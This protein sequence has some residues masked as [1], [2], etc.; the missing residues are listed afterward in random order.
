MASF[1]IFS[2]YDGANFDNGLQDGFRLS[3]TDSH[4]L[5]SSKKILLVPIDME[6][7]Q[8]Y[9]SDGKLYS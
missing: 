7:S 6:L 4:S 9:R 5:P 2:Y 1:F 3:T 8:V